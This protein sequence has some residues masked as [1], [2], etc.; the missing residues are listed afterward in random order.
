MTEFFAEFWE[1]TAAGGM[2]MIALFAL[3]GSI[4]WLAFD[5]LSQLPNRKVEEAEMLEGLRTPV[6]VSL[7]EKEQLEFFKNRKSL[8]QVLAT[9]APLLGLLGTVMGMLATF[10]GLNAS[11][12]NTLD[13][14]AAGISEAMITTE[15]G[16]V[17]AVPALFLIMILGARIQSIENKLAR[18]RVQIRKNGFVVGAAA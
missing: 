17:I 5:T 2:L 14:V 6:D 11:S 8:L 7:F 10:Q 12:G 13:L 4:Y 15:T 18:V 9:T 16:L 1:I 3:A